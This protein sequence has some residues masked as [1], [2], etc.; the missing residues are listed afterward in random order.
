MLRTIKAEK[1]DN[2]IRSNIPYGPNVHEEALAEIDE[3]K[4]LI[5][6][7]GISESHVFKSLGTLG[8]GNHFIEVDKDDDNNFWLVIHSGSRNFGLEIANY[9]INKAKENMKK[10]YT[11]AAYHGLEYL[12]FNEDGT[13]GAREY[14]NDMYTGAFFASV[15]RELI[16]KQIIEKY[17]KLDF[18]NLDKIKR[19][20]SVHNYISAVDNIVRKGAI[21]ATNGE[22]VIIPFNMAYGCAIATGKSS[23][24]YNFSAPHGAGRIMTRED[25][26]HKVDMDFYKKSMK[27]IYSTSVNKHTIDEAPQVY[28]KPKFILESIKD[29]VDIEFFIKPVYNF[30]ADN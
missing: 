21:S 11:G 7:L 24:K 15:N 8:G 18:Y 28:K 16:A 14:I 6:K 13:G 12:T 20:E 19:I 2:F 27:G 29:L 3:F 10:I 9:H 5:S 25:A 30:K 26:K 1:L 17:F 23:E 4:S 22:K